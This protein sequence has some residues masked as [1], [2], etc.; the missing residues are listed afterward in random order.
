M[1][2]LNNSLLYEMASPFFTMDIK[3]ST[4]SPL[5]TAAIQN[6][7]EL[8]S[9]MLYGAYEILS[10]VEKTSR[11]LPLELPQRCWPRDEKGRT[12]FDAAYDRSMTSVPCTDALMLLLARGCGDRRRVDG[13]TENKIRVLD[14]I[15]GKVPDTSGFAVYPSDDVSM[16]ME[17]RKIP[18]VN[19]T[20]DGDKLDTGN[21]KAYISR[22]VESRTSGISWFS[23]L[24]PTIN[25]KRQTR[26]ELK[27]W[28]T[29]ST[30]SAKGAKSAKEVQFCD[31]SNRS[32][33]LILSNK[34]EIRPHYM[35]C[36][37]QC[38]CYANKRHANLNA[39]GRMDPRPCD[40]Q[41]LFGCRFALEIFKTDDDRGWGV[42]TQ[43]GVTIPEKVVV[44]SYSG[45]YVDERE[46]PS[47]EDQY[48]NDGKASFIMNL[49]KLG[50]KKG[51]REHKNGEH[52]VDDATD[53]RGVAGFFNHTC[54]APNLEVKWGWRNHLD[55][56]FPRVIFVTKCTVPPLTE[57][58]FNYGIKMENCMCKGCKRMRRS[59][60]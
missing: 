7:Y 15:G 54:E 58:V 34:L 46:V 44:T 6:N 19:D 12:P 24:N 11:I 25:S 4:M 37:F 23:Y 21:F 27:S 2:L 35:D 47:L 31:Q 16:G 49:H 17:S 18:W 38:P 45:V 56:R 51:A 14:I 13:L 28:P 59:Q 33:A 10:S 32:S 20:G 42:R 30:A 22:S 26:P 40:N 41:Q 8:L 1:D 50:E 43:R 53:F 57:L 9:M 36:N 5:H 52:F 55:G 29:S 48:K 3:N 60:S 39:S